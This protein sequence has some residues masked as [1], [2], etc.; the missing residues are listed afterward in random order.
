MQT[1]N[2]PRFVHPLT[3]VRTLLKNTT[4]K[5]KKVKKKRE[6][7]IFEVHLYLDIL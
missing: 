3:M 7:Q 2:V 5:K 1:I 4:T 6:K